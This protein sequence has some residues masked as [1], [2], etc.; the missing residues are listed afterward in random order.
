M[1]EEVRERIRRFREKMAERRLDA[2]LIPTADFHGSEYVCEYFKCRQYMTGFTGSSGTAVITMKEVGLWTDGRYFV[3]AAAELKDSG[4]RLFKAGTKGTPGVIEYLLENV[5]EGGALGADGR[6]LDA[7]TGEMLQKKLREKRAR[8]SWQEDLVGELWCDRP[9]LPAKPVWILE[10][11]YAGRTMQEKIAAL[12][13]VMRQDRADAHILTTLDDIGWLLNL[14]GA[15]VP[16]TPV[17]LSYVI[18]TEVD[19]LFFVNQEA[20]G[21]EVRQYLEDGGV[22]IFPYE[23]VYSAVGI[24]RHERIMVEKAKINYR[25]FGSLDDSVTIVE[26]RNPTVRMK[27]VKNPV[28]QENLR[29]AHL[30]DGLAVTRFMHWVKNQVKEETLDES[31]AAAWLDQQRRMCPGNLGLSFDT[32]SAYGSNAAMCH[33]SAPEKNSRRLEPKGLYLVD[34]GGQYYEGTTDV[35]R[36]I[37]LGPLT[38]EEK[39]CCTLVAASM[40]R[41]LNVKFLCGCCGIN[42][43]FAARELLWRNGMDFNHGTGHGVGFVNCVH[44]GPNAIRW[45]MAPNLEDNAVLEEGMVTS[46]EPGLYLEGKFGVRT[47]NLMLCVRAEENEFGRFMK[48]ENLTWV[49]IDLDTIDVSILEDRDRALLN[50][51]HREVYARLSPSMEKEELDWL[52]EATRPV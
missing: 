20:I 8:L 23:E 34:S 32:I 31:G 10:P 47:E 12:R 14:R 44:E 3:Q 38:E 21:S 25:L 30:K 11:E 39:K 29:K 52:K 35:T 17:V 15:D 22:Q 46:N 18:V 42:L 28:E 43:D 24:F 16:C 13:A 6:V 50:D 37:A 1:G 36:T 48:F 9:E 49:P 5:P 27:A 51:Y 26:R 4:I 45:R 41:L 33:Y 2:Y 40:L 19:V 7:G